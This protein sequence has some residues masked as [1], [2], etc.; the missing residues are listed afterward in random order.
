MPLYFDATG[1]QRQDQTTWTSPATGD[2]VILDYF[3]LVPDLPASLDDLPKL[4]HDLTVMAGESGCLIEAHV[5]NFGGQPALLRVQKLP[6]PNQP[7]GQGFIASITVPKATCSAVLQIVCRELGT[8]G[9]REAMLA[10]ELGPQTFILDHP[11]APGFTGRLPFHAGDDPQWDPKFPDHPLSRARAWLHHALRTA[12]VDP[13]FAAL[14]G[15]Q[16]APS[17]PAPAPAPQAQPQPQQQQPVPSSQPQAPAYNPQAPGGALQPA[18]APGT[19]M[20]TVVTGFPIG[21]YLPLWFDA[22]TVMY[23]QMSEPGTVLDRL[24]FGTTGRAP[25]DA[26]WFRDALLFD[27]DAQTL[28]M[29]ERYANQDGAIGLLNIEGRL[30][31]LTEAEAALTPENRMAAYR[32]LGRAFEKSAERHEFMILGPGG[33]QMWSE[34]RVMMVVLDADGKRFASLEAT[35]PPA[36]AQIWEQYY[37]P[38]QPQQYFERPVDSP[39]DYVISGEL[40]GFASEVWQCHPLQLAVSFKRMA[41]APQA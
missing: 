39:E 23:W 13:G 30:A 20:H 17:A 1:L 33:V 21:G 4:R 37:K 15:F 6:L 14:P 11:Y 41:D 7:S 5:V 27:L 22:Q 3:D 28:W 40:A 26:E 16:P 24:G 8:T 32:W 34:P 2:H 35:P 19:R 38:D 10:A 12:Q 31:N 36:N 18:P 25:L 9:M 29:A